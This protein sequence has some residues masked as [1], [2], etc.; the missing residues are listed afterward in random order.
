MYWIKN[1]HNMRGFMTSR[2]KDEQVVSQ[3]V[4]HVGRRS[5]NRDNLSYHQLFLMFH[6]NINQIWYQTHNYLNKLR[7]RLRIYDFFE[8]KTDRW[9][10]YCCEASCDSLRI[11][12]I[13]FHN[14][15]ISVWRKTRSETVHEFNF[16]QQF[17]SSVWWKQQR[18]KFRLFNRMRI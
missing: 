6:S 17:G 2:Q 18:P 7:I 5:G 9:T 10:D 11:H 3:L 8:T 13:K 12:V 15:N 16:H 1:Y 14:Q 4:Q